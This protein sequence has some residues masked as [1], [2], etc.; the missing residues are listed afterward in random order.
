MPSASL[1]RIIRQAGR[2]PS[3][4]QAFLPTGVDGIWNRLEELSSWLTS[5]QMDPNYTV[6]TEEAKEW[7]PKIKKQRQSLLDQAKEMFEASQEMSKKY[8]NELDKFCDGIA[9]MILRIGESGEVNVKPLQ[10]VLRRMRDNIYPS[11]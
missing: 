8:H 4:V 3:E 10:I 5:A 1:H 11:S 9:Q 2:V 6:A 7:L